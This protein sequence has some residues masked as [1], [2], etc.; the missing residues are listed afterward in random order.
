MR[1]ALYR[2]AAAADIIGV[3]AVLV[4]LKWPELR[5]FY[6]RFDFEPSRISDNQMF[7]LM[8]D[9]RRNLR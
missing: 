7:L 2:V 4:H 9:L 1:D 5:A 6:E 8:K 3:R